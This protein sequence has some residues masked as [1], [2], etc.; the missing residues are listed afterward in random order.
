MLQPQAVSGIE[1]KN[2][3]GRLRGAG[4]GGVSGNAEAAR[5]AVHR[6]RNPVAGGGDHGKRQ[7]GEIKTLGRNDEFPSAARA[8]RV[9]ERKTAL[10]DDCLLYTSPSP[11]D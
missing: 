10:I 11:R 1:R 4:A 6:Q 5:R 7:N 8:N 2:E 3:G 9:A